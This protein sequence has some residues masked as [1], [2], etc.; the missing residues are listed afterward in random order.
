M[1]NLSYSTDQLLY[2]NP[3]VS[4]FAYSTLFVCDLSVCGLF[5]FVFNS[6]VNVTPLAQHTKMW[7][8]WWLLQG[9]ELT[10][11]NI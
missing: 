6:T 4:Q 8:I 10:Y 7:G 11:H 9:P 2:K 3:S 1:R 5:W